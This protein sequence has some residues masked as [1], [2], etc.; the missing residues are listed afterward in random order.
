MSLSNIIDFRV[1]DPQ[2]NMVTYS[3][4]DYVRQNGNIY[5]AMRETSEYETLMD[6]DLG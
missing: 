5:V 6:L 2:G 4:G 1:R 3:R